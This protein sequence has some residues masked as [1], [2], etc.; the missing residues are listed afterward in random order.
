MSKAHNWQAVPL[1]PAMAKLKRDHRGYPVPS[2]V[3]WDTDGKPHFTINDEQKRQHHLNKDLCS[4]CG[5]KLLKARWSVGGPGSALHEY[6][7]YIDPPMHY[8]CMEYA[9]KVCP[10]LAVPKYFKSREMLDKDALKAKVPGLT[11]LADPTMLDAKPEV[12]VAVMHVGQAYVMEGQFK[13]YVR[14]SRPFRRMEYW[15]GGKKLDDAT[16]H[17][18]A[19]EQL[20]ALPDDMKTG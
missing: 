9:L 12:F 8:G 2:I 19:M 15:S 6:G 16:G 20:E 17:A 10:Y 13:R 7:A 5:N 11:V 4:I 14:P 3:L 18:L 1:P